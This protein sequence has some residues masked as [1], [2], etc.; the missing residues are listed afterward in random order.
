VTQDLELLRELA[1]KDL[2]RVSLSITSLDPELSRR[3]EPRASTPQK[4]LEAIEQL[5]SAGVNVGVNV[6]P[7]I[8]G[9][10]DH[11][12]PAI[13]QAA[14]QRGAKRAGFI[15]LRL[16]YGVKDIFVEWLR[17]CYPDRAEK[18]IH[19]IEA[20]RGGKLNASG[21]GLRMTGTGIRAELVEQMF[22][23]HCE[24]LGLNERQRPLS[25]EHFR[26]PG[27]QQLDLLSGL[28]SSVAV[29]PPSKA[30]SAQ[31]FKDMMGVGDEGDCVPV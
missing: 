26:R 1:R 17:R 24:R 6:A 3:M 28:E 31:T 18:V 15:M 8:P 19:G 9:L 4:R 30:E 25:L 12:V 20:M 27:N 14:A 22:A 10:N 7:V 16:P 13:L 2:V 5:V 11:E 29:T 23:L 21:F